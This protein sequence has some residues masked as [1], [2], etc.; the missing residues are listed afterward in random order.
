[1]REHPFMY[2][3]VKG[4]ILKYIIYFQEKNKFQA[5]PG[6]RHC[7][8]PKVQ[9]KDCI[10]SKGE[11]EHSHVNYEKEMRFH[12]TLIILKMLHC[13]TASVYFLGALA[14]WQGERCGAFVTI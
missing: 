6:Y 9:L 8:F 4:R 1:M 5:P 11:V 7:A 2:A 14:I 13:S 12:S 10:L 3:Q